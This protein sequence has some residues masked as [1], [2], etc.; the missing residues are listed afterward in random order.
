[1]INQYTLFQIFYL[2]TGECTEG[3]KV[4]SNISEAASGITMKNLDKLGVQ[5]VSRILYY[6]L[7][8]NF[9]LIMNDDMSANFCCS[10]AD[11]E[12]IQ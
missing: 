7:W 10:V 9:I 8:I 6:K 11:N 3:I 12:G 4:Y 2:L 5:D 1:M